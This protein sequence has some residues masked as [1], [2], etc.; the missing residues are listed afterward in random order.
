MRDEEVVR[1]WLA[2]SEDDLEAARVLDRAS[3][4]ALA[5]FHAPQAA[6]KALEAVAIGR[7]HG[8]ARTHDLGKLAGLARAPVSVVE[9]TSFLNVFYVGARYPDAGAAVTAADVTGAVRAAQ[10]VLAWCRSQIS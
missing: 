3:L 10:E 6:E 2:R 5:A 9:A 7:G 8:L 1:D 4:R